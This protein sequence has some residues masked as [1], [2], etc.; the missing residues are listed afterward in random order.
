MN[1]NAYEPKSERAIAIPVHFLTTALID[2][3]DALAAVLLMLQ[4]VV[5]KPASGGMC[6][7]I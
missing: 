6:Y 4:L 1:C 2:M 7:I 3:M 5:L